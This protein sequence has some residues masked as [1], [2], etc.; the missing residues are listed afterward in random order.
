MITP[1]RFQLPLTDRGLERL[2]QVDVMQDV[3]DENVVRAGFNDSGVSKNNRVIANRQLLV[4]QHFPFLHEDVEQLT[5]I[6]DGHAVAQPHAEGAANLLQ[7]HLAMIEEGDELGN[8][9]LEVNVVLPERVIG[10]D[11]QGLGGSV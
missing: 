8:R 10:I 11:E 1:L 9:S 5:S 2:L 4:K 6:G 3:Q 7:R